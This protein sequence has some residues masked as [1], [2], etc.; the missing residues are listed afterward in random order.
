MEHDEMKQLCRRTFCEPDEKCLYS[1]R[2][3]ENI[4]CHQTV[5][6]DEEDVQFS[7]RTLRETDN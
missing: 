4:I 2:D 5:E 7:M 6:G 1:K 3:M